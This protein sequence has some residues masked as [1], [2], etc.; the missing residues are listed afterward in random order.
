MNKKSLSILGLIASGFRR[1]GLQPLL[2]FLRN[3]L[4]AG[5]QLLRF[6]PLAAEID[7]I[8]LHGYLRHRS[9]LEQLAGGTYESATRNL[10]RKL[11]P[12]A[13]VFIDAGAHIGLFSVLASRYGTPGLAVL[14]FEPDPYNQ[15]AFRWNV[16]VN[17][18]KNVEL[19]PAAVSDK[20]GLARLLISDGTIGSSLVLGRTEVGGTHILEVETV[21]LDTAVKAAAGR[22]ILAKLDIEGAEISALDGMAVL[23]RNAKRIGIICEVNPEALQ[24]GDR[25]PMDLIVRLRTAG[26]QVFFISEETGGVVPTG[27]SFHAKGN[28]F[29]VRD[30]SVDEGWIRA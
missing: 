14:S 27:D 1:T 20:I 26:L 22:A 29:A 25:T 21:T 3:G 2:A 11:L 23:L 15:R 18:C 7:G 24:A 6:P 17:R 28:L 10:F 30:W 5:F 16:R 8:R 12:S 4:D 13:E 19:F 9:I